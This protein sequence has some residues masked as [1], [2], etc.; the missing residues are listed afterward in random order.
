VIDEALGA[1]DV[2]F[3]AKCQEI[4]EERRATADV[5]M[6]SHSMMMV[7]QYCSKAGV[8]WGGK[9]TMYDNV[10]EANEH[11]LRVVA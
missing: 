6:V 7:R 8:L 2:A 4:F 3:Q 11:Y 9:L 1:G 5:I 10:E